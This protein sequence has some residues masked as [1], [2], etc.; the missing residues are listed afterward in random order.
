MK[1]IIW[2]S[3]ALILVIAAVAGAMFWL[4][5]PQVVILKDGTKLTLVGV[6]YGKHHVFKGAKTTG[7]HLHGRTTFDTTNDTLMVWIE[8]E[9]PHEHNDNPY[10]WPNYQLMTYDSADT[11]CV[12]SWQ[13][14]GQQIKNGVYVQGFIINAF[15]RRERKIILRVGAWGNYGG[16]R[17][18]KG[19]F[20]ISNPG[21]R[22]FPQW[23][24]EPMPD[25]QSDGDLDVTLTR[26]VAGVPSN[27]YGPADAGSKDPMQKGVSVSFHT[28]QYG[29]VVTN[30]Q[31]VAI[32]TSDATGNQ[33]DQRNWSSSR[34]DNGDPTMT[35][36]W[37]LWP[38]ESAWKLRVEMSR[39][40]GFTNSEIWTVTNVP[41]GKG[42]WNELWNFQMRRHFMNGF[43]QNNQSSPPFAETTLNGVHLKL[44]PAIQITGQNFGM[45][46]KQ[47]GFHITTDPDIPDGYRLSLVEA[48][49]ERGRKL[50]SWGPNGQNGNSVFQ[51]PDIGNA[52]FLNLTIALHKSRFVEFTVKPTKQ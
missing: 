47:G 40:S 37:G 35:Y 32:E 20:V 39:T 27:M 14:T 18:A 26:C 16:L 28:E 41:V 24:P 13:T 8:S 34:D 48:T 25:T 29:K 1:K 43:Q 21:P 49:D 44:Y 45:G 15:P 36:Q 4:R 9:K 52:K 50:Q 31:P 10:Q 5:R 38:D 6:S 30:W 42:S 51:I 2:G 12:G 3:V 46:Q 33:V 11:A 22:S 7:S 19:Q 17:L 23:Q